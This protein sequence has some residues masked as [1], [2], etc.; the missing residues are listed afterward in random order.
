LIRSAGAG[1]LVASV[2]YLVKERCPRQALIVGVIIA[3]SAGSWIVYSR[4]HA[5]TPEQRA[6]QSGSILEPYNEQFW[7]RVAGNPSAGSITASE[8]PSRVWKNLSEISR[9]DMG[10]VPLYAFYRAVAPG[11]QVLLSR[12]AIW[13]S[14]ALTALAIIGFIA[15]ARERMT[16]AEFVTPLSLA[17]SILWGWEQFRFLLPLIPFLIFYQLMGLRAVL[18]LLARYRTSARSG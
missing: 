9:V 10:A 7:H 5:P 11:Q 16:L 14:L 4:A 6:E 17:T 13:L 12:P 18:E 1:L 2:L 3:I 8:L 15:A